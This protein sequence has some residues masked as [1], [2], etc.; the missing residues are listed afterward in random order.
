MAASQ[1]DRETK[2]TSSILT[3]ALRVGASVGQLLTD[4]HVAPRTVVVGLPRARRPR[5][6]VLHARAYYRA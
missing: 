5:S 4:A 2:L 6:G 1:I 3:S